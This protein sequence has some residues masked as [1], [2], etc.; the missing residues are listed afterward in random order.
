MSRSVMPYCT[1]V[2]H[3]IAIDCSNHII[4]LI[5]TIFYRKIV[6]NTLK[7]H[8]CHDFYSICKIV[9]FIGEEGER[10]ITFIVTNDNY[11]FY[12]YSNG[13]LIIIFLGVL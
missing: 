12:I 7:L 10:G 4:D 9:N 2:R 11:F 3:F 1:L 5:L 13:Y 8:C 6:F